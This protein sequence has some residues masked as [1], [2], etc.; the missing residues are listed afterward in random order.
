MQAP[1][2]DQ[3]KGRVLAVDDCATMRLLLQ[4]ALEA[5]GYSVFAVD[6][7]RAALDAIGSGGFDA[8]ILDVEMPEVDGMAVGRA[9]RDNPRTAATLIALHTSLHESDVRIGF[10]QYDDFLVK[11]FGLLALGERLDRLML[12]RI[13]RGPGGDGATLVRG[14]MLVG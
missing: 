9:L 8:V 5:S 4:A 2:R 6:G 3:S 11:P 14:A 10:D 13:Q 1:L 12:A 7:G